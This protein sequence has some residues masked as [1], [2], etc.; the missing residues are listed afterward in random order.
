MLVVSHLQ[1]YQ[2]RVHGQKCADMLRVPLSLPKENADLKLIRALPSTVYKAKV[3][4][5]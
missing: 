1:L 5:P 3:A 4:M 2:Q